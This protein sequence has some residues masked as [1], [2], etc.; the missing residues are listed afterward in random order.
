MREEDAKKKI[1]PFRNELFGIEKPTNGEI[2]YE[3]KSANCKGSGCM[4][5]QNGNCLRLK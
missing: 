1:C 4:A 5:W 3:S 2:K